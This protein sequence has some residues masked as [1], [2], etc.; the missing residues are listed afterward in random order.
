MQPGLDDRIETASI[1]E[2]GPQSLIGWDG[3]GLVKIYNRLRGF[4][5]HFEVEKIG[6]GFCVD[7][8]MGSKLAA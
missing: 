6:T 4:K 5:A 3:P 7:H 1:L 8:N 2:P